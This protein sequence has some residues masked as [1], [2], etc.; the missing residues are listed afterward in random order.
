MSRQAF[1]APRGVLSY[2]TLFPIHTQFLDG[3]KTLPTKAYCI[4]T[5]AR[6]SF[7]R[8]FFIGQGFVSC[9]GNNIKRQVF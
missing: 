1:S 9:G 4:R 3:P 5:I 2:E 8:N 7:I 6:L